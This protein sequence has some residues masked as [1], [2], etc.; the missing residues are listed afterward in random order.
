MVAVNE[1]RVSGQILDPFALHLFGSDL[2]FQLIY[3]IPREHAGGSITDGD[4]PG[5]D[6][7]TIIRMPAGPTILSDRLSDPTQYFRAVQEPFP[8]GTQSIE[9][10]ENATFFISM[11]EPNSSALYDSI[12]L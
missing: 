12:R 4:R 1:T 10:V 8:N 5:E 3:I 11:G 7:M 6:E 9:Q 2:Y